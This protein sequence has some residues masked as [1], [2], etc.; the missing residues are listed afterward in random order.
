MGFPTATKHRPGY[1]TIL[2]TP[3]TLNESAVEYA[4]LEWFAQLDDAVGHGLDF[5]PGELAV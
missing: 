5:A 3:M 4:P 2:E 1:A